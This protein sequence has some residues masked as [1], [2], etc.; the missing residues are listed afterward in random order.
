[1][2]PF[3]FSPPRTERFRRQR[4][5]HPLTPSCICPNA[6]EESEVHRYP[7]VAEVFL[8]LPDR[9]ILEV[10]DRG[11][12]HRIGPAFNNGVVEVSELSRPARCNHRDIHRVAHRLIQFV[13]VASHGPVGVHT[14]QQYLACAQF[15][16]PDR[17]FNN[18][19][20]RRLRP[21]LYAHLPLPR[22][23]LRPPRIDRQHHALIAKT[24]SRLPKNLRVPHRR[25]RMSRL[26]TEK[27]SSP[28]DS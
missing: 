13:V 1:M 28:T 21:R 26:P 12:Q 4:A 9:I 24:H 11:H 16:A 2:R 7:A 15:L 3:L 23:I 8:H 25:S 5:N 18:V 14:R 17:P 19:D 20:I 27:W 6:L 22:L 10:G